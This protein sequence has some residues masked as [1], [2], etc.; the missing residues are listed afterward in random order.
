MHAHKSLLKGLVRVKTSSHSIFY[1]KYVVNSFDIKRDSVAC[2]NGHQRTK[3]VQIAGK[4]KD[5][6]VFYH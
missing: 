3:S 6:H 5:S 2:L 1:T 4:F